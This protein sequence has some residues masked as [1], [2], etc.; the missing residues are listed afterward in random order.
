MDASLLASL[1]RRRAGGDPYAAYRSHI[2]SQAGGGDWAFTYGPAAAGYPGAPSITT[3]GAPTITAEKAVFDGTDDAIRAD[4]TQN[5]SGCSLFVVANATA[6]NNTQDAVIQIN[7]GTT[8]LVALEA[9]TSGQFTTRMR[10]PTG[11]GGSIINTI[12][13]SN[14]T[15]NVLGVTTLM[16]LIFETD[17]YVYGINGAN[18]AGRTT[19]PADVNMTRLIVGRAATQYIGADIYEVMLLDT[20]D[21]VIVDS[22]LR[23]ASSRF[24][25]SIPVITPL[26]RT[27]IAFTG[28]SIAAG[29]GASVSTAE[30]S[31]L[32]A[33]NFLGD[34]TE[35]GLADS[36][37]SPFGLVSPAEDAKI[38]ACFSRVMTAGNLSGK[39]AVVNFAGAN[40]RAEDVPLGAAGSADENELNGALNNG[41]ADFLANRD[42]G[43]KLYVCT[44]VNPNNEIVNGL[45]LTN[46]DYDAAIRAA[47]TRANDPDVL[48]C[49]TRTLGLTDPT[50]FA[51]GVHPN[52]VGYAKIAV[53]ITTA[54]AAQYGL[55]R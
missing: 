17:G 3:E 54:I 47:V 19:R 9:Q 43:A 40:D 5:Y 39:S 1:R 18:G 41:I 23:D 55:S 11:Y 14:G 7:P 29:V 48:L 45:G 8:D 10:C 28:D 30:F 15:T 2:I 26:K 33:K 24:G 36:Q 22:Y 53:Y 50:D 27:D 38:A 6:T 52:D 46:A 49:D 35:L 16:G 37:I 34:R 51:D 20:T 13:P 44:T 32:V 4:I 42:A 25:V 21:P 31:W 12:N